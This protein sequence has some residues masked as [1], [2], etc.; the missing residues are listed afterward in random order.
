MARATQSKPCVWGIQNLGLIKDSVMPLSKL[1]AK[2]GNLEEGAFPFPRALLFKESLFAGQ[3]PP[4][5]RVT[6]GLQFLPA[7]SAPLEEAPFFFTPQPSLGSQI[8]A[9]CLST[10]YF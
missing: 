4:P 10:L 3:Q 6:T 9:M 8:W 5:P 1:R 2:E 7:S